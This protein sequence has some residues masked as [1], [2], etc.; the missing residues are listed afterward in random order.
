MK[1]DTPSSVGPT[2]RKIGV[3]TGMLSVSTPF[4]LF[5]IALAFSHGVAFNPGDIRVINNPGADGISRS[6]GIQ[7]IMPARNIEL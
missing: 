3:E 6:W 7:I 5:H 2:V 1:T 4:D